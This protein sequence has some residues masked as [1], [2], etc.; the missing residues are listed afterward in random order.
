[1]ET[2]SYS[3]R[4]ENKIE[5]LHRLKNEVDELGNKWNIN[6]E[7]I[8]DLH[9]AFEEIITNII[10]YGYPDQ[11]LHFI[12]IFISY[13]QS[14]L[15]VQIEDDGIEFDPLKKADPSFTEDILDS[16]IGGWGIYLCKKVLDEINYRRFENKNIL[17]FKKTISQLHW[18][19]I[20][21]VITESRHDSIVILKLEGRLDITSV[22]SLEKKLNESIDNGANKIILDCAA[23]NFIS[24]AGLRVLIIIQKKLEPKKGELVIFGFNENTKKIFEITGYF[25]LFSIFETESEAIKHFEK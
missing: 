4:L 6:S 20:N 18:K 14:E 22:D 9:L 17:T 10:F 5:E 12:S 13:N 7:V 19:E 21:M 25:N 16:K 3:I 15:D 23:L 2:V 11:S 8:F 24:S 1:L